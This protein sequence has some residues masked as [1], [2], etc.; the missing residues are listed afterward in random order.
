MVSQRTKFQVLR[1]NLYKAI[2]GSAKCRKLG[3]LGQLG[4]LKGMG[5]ASIRQSTYDFLLDFNSRLTICLSFNVFEIQPVI[6]RKSPIFTH[7]PAFGAHARVD[8]GRISRRSLTSEK[9]NP[10]AIVWCY[11][12]DPTFSR[13][14]RTPTCVRRT[15]AD[16]DSQSQTQVHGQY[17]GCIASRGKNGC[18]VNVPRATAT[19]CRSNHTRPKLPILKKFAKIGGVLYNRIGLEPI[20]KPEAVSAVRVT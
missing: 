2:S 10:W 6:C 13:F 3:G 12:C 1:F 19:Q 9:Q 17:R 7:T 8:A 5:N 20:V 4:A 14:S 18:Y 11:V 16:T 15:Q